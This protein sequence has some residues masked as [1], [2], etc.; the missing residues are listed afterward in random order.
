MKK[1]TLI[2]ALVFA[3]IFGSVESKAQQGVFQFGYDNVFQG[4]YIGVGGIFYDRVMAT[5]E[6]GLSSE[7]IIPKVDVSA[8]FLRLREAEL[9]FYLGAGYGYTFKAIEDVYANHMY[10]G[11]FSVHY[12]DFFIGYG[13]GF[14]QTLNPAKEGIGNYH[15]F[16]L[17]IAL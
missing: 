13:L 14:Y 8:R 5:L 6:C 10:E 16:K 4:A 7:Y 12:H 3:G 9:D 2:I 1:I 17:G 15:Y 11:I